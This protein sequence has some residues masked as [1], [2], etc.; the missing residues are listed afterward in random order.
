MKLTAV[1]LTVATAQFDPTQDRRTKQTIEML[2]NYVTSA[3]KGE[4]YKKLVG[5]G[6][7]CFSVSFKQITKILWITVH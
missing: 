5:Y 2:D 1:L 4:V 6:C 3:K 7:N